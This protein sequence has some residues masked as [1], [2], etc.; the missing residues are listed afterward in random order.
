MY[1]N[2]SVGSVQ[3]S[4]NI[5]IGVEFIL[6]DH[7]GLYIDPSLR[8]YFRNSKAPKSI[9]TVQPLMLGFEAGFRILL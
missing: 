6:T 1:Y 3:F 4:A 5:G 9:R 7:L 2:G 8:Y